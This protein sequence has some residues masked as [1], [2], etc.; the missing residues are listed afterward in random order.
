MFILDWLKDG[1]SFI[2]VMFHQ[3]LSAIGMN[4]DSGWTWTFSIVGLVI[5][6]RILLI[7]L[8]VKQIKAQRESEDQQVADD[9]GRHVDVLGHFEGKQ[10]RIARQC[11]L[12]RM[13]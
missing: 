1:V 10:A 13:V 9:E 11:L 2:L 12:A 5:V 8:F 6:I 4:P 7:P 3:A